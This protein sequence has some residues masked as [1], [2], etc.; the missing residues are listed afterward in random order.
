MSRNE[1]CGGDWQAARPLPVFAP[2]TLDF[3]ADVSALLLRSPEARAYPDIVTFAFFCR[4]AHLKQL[5][6]AYDDADERMGRGM[7]FHIAPSNVPINFAYS[8]VAGLLAGNACVVKASS[9]D[10]VQTRLVCAAMKRC[11]DDGH[12][13]MAPYV[14]VLTYPREDQAQTESLSAAC[15]GRVIWGGDETVRRVRQAALPQHAVEVAF[16]D[17]YSL[18]VIR[19]QAFLDMDDAALKR[20]AQ[21]FFN[22]TY[23]TDQNAC[24]APRLLY[25]L[26]QDVAAAQDRFWQAVHAYA[27][28]RYTIEPVVAV[29]KLTA[30]CRAAIDLGA[31]QQPMPDNVAVRVQLPSL[32]P[33]VDQYRCPGGFFAEYA[34]PTL[35]PLAQVVKRKY[36]TLSCIGMDPAGLR[37]FVMERG[38]TGVDRIVPVGHT[39]DFDLVWDGCDLIRTLSRRITAR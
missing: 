36:Q 39:L 24:T 27:A 38:L 1:L 35:E 11:L 13:A 23:L 16:A 21:D 20:L 34:A 29:D 19:S 31:R 6:T 33:D 7:V 15:D 9:R 4:G 10:F 28:S 26:G 12:S 25:W 37:R 22:D 8:L 2:R 30:A 5:Q 14:T 32:T 3:L 18:L 17:R